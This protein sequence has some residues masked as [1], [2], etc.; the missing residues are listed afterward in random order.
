MRH[1][2]NALCLLAVLWTAAWAAPHVPAFV[3]VV[4]L[5]ALVVM[6]LIWLVDEQLGRTA[7]ARA[8]LDRRSPYDC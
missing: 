8:H 6:A 5:V 3:T 2:P 7:R 1:L 4:M